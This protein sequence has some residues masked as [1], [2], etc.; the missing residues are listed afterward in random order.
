MWMDLRSLWLSKT[1]AFFLNVYFV[2]IQN[3]R[4]L[5]DLGFRLCLILIKCQ[6]VTCFSFSFSLLI[7]V[8]NVV[9]R[10]YRGFEYYE[11]WNPWVKD[12][13]MIDTFWGAVGQYFLPLFDSLFGNSDNLQYHGW[14]LP[15]DYCCSLIAAVFFGLRC[16]L[17]SWTLPQP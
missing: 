3:R 17:P 8:A 12:L 2:Y 6:Y 10:G 4:I 16:R 9:L 1:Y 5:Q 14:V 13:V 7:C 11:K 15:L